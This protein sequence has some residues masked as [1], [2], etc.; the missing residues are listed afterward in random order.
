MVVWD[1]GLEIKNPHFAPKLLG[2]LC[3]FIC[4]IKGDDLP[5]SRFKMLCPIF[6]FQKQLNE[7]VEGSAKLRESPPWGRKQDAPNSRCGL[8]PKGRVGNVCSFCS[9]NHWSVIC[10]HTCTHKLTQA[11][12]TYIYT[13]THIHA[14]TYTCTCTYSCKDIPQSRGLTVSG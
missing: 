8:E 7:K 13:D 3:F 2:G 4:A 1:T 14:H 12:H 10:T 9:Q 5:P 11:H 6:Q